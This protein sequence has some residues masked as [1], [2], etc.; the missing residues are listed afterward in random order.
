MKS[1]H[2][3]IP[4]LCVMVLALSFPVLLSA[5]TMGNSQ[6]YDLDA[7]WAKAQ[8]QYDLKAHD[9]ILLLE[10]RHASILENGNLKTRVHRVVWIGTEMGID[11]YADLRI[12][13]LHF[14]Q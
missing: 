1:R 2:N 11:H 4:G 5:A 12:T 8:K 13:G 6:G 14:P 9:A 10:G 3:I 7:L